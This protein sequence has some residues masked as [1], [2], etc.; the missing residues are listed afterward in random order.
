M[1]YVRSCQPGPDRDRTYG[2]V[3]SRTTGRVRSA[4]RGRTCG[5]VSLGQAARGA[6]PVSRPLRSSRD[7]DGLECA[8]AG[9]APPRT[10]RSLPLRQ[11][12]RDVSANTARAA[13]RESG[14]DARAASASPPERSG[15]TLRSIPRSARDGPGCSIPDPPR[16]PPR[17]RQNQK[18]PN[19]RRSS[20][21]RPR[22]TRAGTTSG[23]HRWGCPTPSTGT[24]ARGTRTRQLHLPLGL[25]RQEQR[26]HPRPRLG[27]HEAAPRPV[28]LAAGSERAWSPS[29]PT[30][31]AASAS[32]RSPSGGSSTRRSRLGD[33]SPA[34]AEHDPADLCR[35]GQPVPAERPAGRRQLR[36]AGPAVGPVGSAVVREP[37]VSRCAAPGSSA[38]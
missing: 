35:E 1:T 29:T 10:A 13:A 12:S 2:S 18:P 4:H 20:R 31:R 23:S 5:H 14:W 7:H 22:R 38:R 11:A 9:T 34:G 21:S 26:L 19:R 24:A 17:R 33:R 27:R 36:A 3:G 6:F 16:L 32:T 30:P 25:R 15:T 37:P 28:R 8:C